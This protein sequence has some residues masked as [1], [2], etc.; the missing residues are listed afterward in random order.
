MLR[1]TLRSSFLSGPM[2]EKARMY[3]LRVAWCVYGDMRE[4][5]AKEIFVSGAKAGYSRR[6]SSASS[7]CSLQSDDDVEVVRPDT[8]VSTETRA[9]FA[10][11]VQDPFSKQP[12]LGSVD[13]TPTFSPMNS[14]EE[15]PEDSED[16][17]DSVS[18]YST[19]SGDSDIDPELSLDDLLECDPEFDFDFDVPTEQVV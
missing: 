8:D 2:A 1:S 17:E 12:F 7:T 10:W 19:I 14:D 3:G 6:R 18:E 11:S 16:S 15:D 13:E 4:M 5:L 9:A